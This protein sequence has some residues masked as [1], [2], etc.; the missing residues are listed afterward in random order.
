[1]K[2]PNF[3]YKWILI[4]LVVLVVLVVIYFFWSQSDK[5]K[6]VKES[7]AAIDHDK[8]HQYDQCNKNPFIVKIW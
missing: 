4:A 3:D 2:L 1:M 7:N 5:Q 8:N 6:K